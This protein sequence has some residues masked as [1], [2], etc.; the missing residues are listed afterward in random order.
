MNGSL[1]YEGNGNCCKD[2][3]TQKSASLVQLTCNTKRKR[4]KFC[5]ISTLVSIDIVWDSGHGQDPMIH[6]VN[7][8]G[9][10]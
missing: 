8:V 2:V 3:R 5:V 1:K 7:S 4:K 9:F 10:G 6:G